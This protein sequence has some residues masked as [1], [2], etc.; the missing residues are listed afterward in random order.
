M[1]A[2]V[3]ATKSDFEAA[4]DEDLNVSEALG[5]VFRL[6]R[7][8]NQFLDSTVPN[9]PIGAKDALSFLDD[10]EDVFG[11]L[12][13]MDEEMA[14]AGEAGEEVIEWAKNQL[15]DRERAR[16]KRDFEQADAIRASLEAKGVVVEDLAETT[17]LR[18]GS[19]SVVVPRSRR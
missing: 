8:T 16:E 18:F 9:A 4:M 17:R 3:E 6:V 13:L 1:R 14:G 19:Q 11:V 10:F 5:A 2:D 15:V 12:S 7:D